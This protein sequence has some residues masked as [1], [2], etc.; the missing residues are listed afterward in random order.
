MQSVKG[1]EGTSMDNE[2]SST[3]QRRAGIGNNFLPTATHSLLS[4]S[5]PNNHQPHGPL[6][7]GSFGPPRNNQYESNSQFETSLQDPNSKP[8]QQSIFQQI[9]NLQNPKQS[10]DLNTKKNYV[11]HEENPSKT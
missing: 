8:I 7:V 10:S 1:F 2:Q 5:Q 9:P 11:F 6:R 3:F 4:Q